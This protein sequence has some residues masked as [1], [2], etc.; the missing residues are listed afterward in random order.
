MAVEVPVADARQISIED[1]D[2]GEHSLVLVL[3]R[4][5]QVEDLLHCIPSVVLRH[6]EV[7]HLGVLLFGTIFQ[8]TF[9]R[10]VV[11]DVQIVVH[12]HSFLLLPDS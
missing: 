12:L 4:R 1:A 3:L 9:E 7:L 6:E 2:C 5:V 8:I 11:L 10:R